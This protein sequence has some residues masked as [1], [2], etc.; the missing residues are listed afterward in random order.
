MA[1]TRWIPLMLA[2]AGSF[3]LFSPH[4]AAAQAAAPP[5]QS[6]T[7]IRTET[8]LV[9]VDT[10]VTDKKGG[11][12]HGLEA[13]NFH[14]YEDD[15]E[16]TIKSFSF[17]NDAAPSA[18]GSQHYL[19]LFFDNSTLDPSQ[20]TYARRAAA[21]FIDANAGQNRLMAIVNFGGSLQLA[22]NFTS[23]TDRLKKVVSGVKFSAVNPNAGDSTMVAS[24][25]SAGLS[26]AAREF[27]ARGLLQALRSLARNLA[28]VPGRKS[29][30]LLTGGMPLTPDIMSDLTALINA[31]NKSNVAV[32]PIDAR[33]L[34][35]GILGS[36]LAPRRNPLFRPASFEPGTA[37]APVVFAPAAFLYQRPGGGGGPAGG[38]GGRTAPS[39]S[40]S[41]SPGRTTPPTAPGRGSTPMNPGTSPGR[42]TPG[43]PGG[44]SGRPTN[45][46]M[47]APGRGAGVPGYPYNPVIYNSPYSSGRQIIPILPPSPSGNQS[48]LYALAAGTGGFVIANSNDLLGGM[49]KIGREQ[50][51]YYLIGYS[52]AETPEG[53]CHTIKVKVEGGGMSV[54]AR[55]GYCNVRPTD[56]LAGSSA[57]KELEARAAAGAGNIHAAMRAPF[58]YTSPNTAKVNVAMEMPTDSIKFEKEKGKFRA[59]INVLGIVSNADGS[60]AARFS[61][62]LPLQLDKKKDVETFKEQPLH[63]ESQFDVAS[64]KYT[65]RVAF[66]SGGE[67]FGKV[68]IPLVVEPYDGKQLSLSGIALAKSL[69]KID[70]GGLS[71]D[72]ALEDRKIL[73]SQGFQLVPTGTSQIKKTEK[74]LLYVEVYEPALLNETPPMVAIQLRILDRK[75]GEAK[76]DTGLMNLASMIKSGSSVI[77]VGMGL[78]IGKLESGAYRAELKVMDSQGRSTWRSAEFELQ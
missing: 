6:G 31:C 74:P 49:E 8:R 54:R 32:Y 3:L 16:Q 65:L 68:E 70:E 39:P 5:A 1:N 20:Q 4:R 7:T 26:A 53:S 28:S 64:G 24:L 58:F 19:V 37:G 11:Y 12:V 77:P 75:T 27:G 23:D 66:S 45:P 63:Y 61:D 35:S 22:Q 36:G 47:T 46:G 69:V 17:E 56:L 62:T 40:P 43:T 57:E 18:K 30:I 10:I 76:D 50:S 33:G 78:P 29:L 67:S 34:D 51:E 71:L 14:V 38:G 48:I 73:V 55:S 25:G 44:V 41:P 60:V 2:A 72:A 42:T 13:R 21:K 59:A 9:I 52:P 15:H